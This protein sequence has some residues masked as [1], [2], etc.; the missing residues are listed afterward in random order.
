MEVFVVAVVAVDVS[1][2]THFWEFIFYFCVISCYTNTTHANTKPHTYTHVTHG[3][4][5]IHLYV[6]R[7]CYTT[8]NDG[9]Q[10]SK[11]KQKNC[12]VKEAYTEPCDQWK[13]NNHISGFFFFSNFIWIGRATS[14]CRWNRMCREWRD[15]DKKSISRMQHIDENWNWF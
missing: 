11:R 6:D 2:C 14:N 10:A 4:A 12:V 1:M 3:K 15:I 5:E 13:R 8:M 9:M 7:L